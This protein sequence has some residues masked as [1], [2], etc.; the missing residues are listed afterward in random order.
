MKI[1]D[2]IT[3]KDGKITGYHSGNIDVNFAGTAYE[4]H[5]RIRVPKNCSVVTGDNIHCYKKNWSKK[6]LVELYDEGYI[7]NADGY[8]RESY[9]VREMTEE[10]RI[11]SG[12]DDI[13]I[14]Y[15]I[16]DNNIVPST[17]DEQFEAKQITREEYNRKKA[18]QNIAALNE[19]L[20][21]L[22]TPEC[23]ALAEVNNE[24]C[25]W[26]KDVFKKL[27]AVKQQEGFPI[28]A[29]FPDIQELQWM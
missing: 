3:V 27:L 16:V 10:E 4:G 25:L 2:F 12:I 24:Y 29:V 26:R 15:K 19:K 11:L 28:N 18:E 14:G 6:T 8:I 21:E 13:P 1:I 20:L 7:T 23:V 5:K 9:G 22:Q 17:L